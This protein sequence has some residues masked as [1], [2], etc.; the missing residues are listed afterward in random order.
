[1]KEVMVSEDESLKIVQSAIGLFA[2]VSFRHSTAKVDTIDFIGMTAQRMIGKRLT[3]KEL[4]N[5]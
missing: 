5:A 3:Y 1:M 2:P 4:I